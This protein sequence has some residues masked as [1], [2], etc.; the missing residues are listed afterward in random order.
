MP[1]TQAPIARLFRARRPGRFFAQRSLVAREMEKTG[2]RV[3]CCADGAAARSLFS[4]TPE[5]FELLILD[6]EARRQPGAVLAAEALSKSPELKILLL[7]TEPR[8]GEEPGP[9]LGQGCR[10]LHKPFGITELRDAVGY[11]LGP[12]RRTVVGA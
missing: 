6:R 8:P 3:F 7:G 10:V 11:L 2:R 12:G 9:D 1:V 5:R 4:A